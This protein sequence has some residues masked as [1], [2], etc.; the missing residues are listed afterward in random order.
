MGQ[1]FC[2]NLRAHFK[3]RVRRA[4]PT[5][6]LELLK[7]VDPESFKGSPEKMTAMKV[8]QV[9]SG[10]PDRAWTPG[11]LGSLISYT[12]AKLS[13]ALPLQQAWGSCLGPMPLSACFC[14]CCLLF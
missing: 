6:T 1:N 9:M 4:T 14:C 5:S 10:R 11:V 13:G 12:V 3:K 8:V 7:Q 2:S